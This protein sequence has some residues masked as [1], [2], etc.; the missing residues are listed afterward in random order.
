MVRLA[1]RVVGCAFAAACIASAMGQASDEEEEVAPVTDMDVGSFHTVVILRDTLVNVVKDWGANG[2]GQVSKG[3]LN[4]SSPT[5]QQAPSKSCVSRTFVCYDL[6]SRAVGI[7]VCSHT[8]CKTII[9]LL[10][11]CHFEEV[12]HI[13]GCRMATFIVFVRRGY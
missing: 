4:Y 10:M 5:L 3:R 12:V 7:T 11:L 8:E 9:V 13:E 1:S 6:R 2:K